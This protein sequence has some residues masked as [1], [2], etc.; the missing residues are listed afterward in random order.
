MVSQSLSQY[1]IK[2][3]SPGNILETLEARHSGASAVKYGTKIDMTK[4][5]DS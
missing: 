2:T 3:H 1:H 4:V 5:A